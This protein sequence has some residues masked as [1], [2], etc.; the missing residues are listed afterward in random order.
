MFKSPNKMSKST[1]KHH[2]LLGEKK[3]DLKQKRIQ[4]NQ[5]ENFLEGRSI[6]TSK[7]EGYLNTC[8]ISRIPCV[9]RCQIIQAGLLLLQEPY[10]CSSVLILQS[11]Y[12]SIKRMIVFLIFVTVVPNYINPCKLY[13]GVKLDS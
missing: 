10:V 3:S 7:W 13:F 6:V 4:W 8:G 12:I 2:V 9:P 5:K 11:S 1:V